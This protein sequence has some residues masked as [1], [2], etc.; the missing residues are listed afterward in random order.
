MNNRKGKHCF[1]C[2]KKNTDTDTSKAGYQ[3]RRYSVKIYQKI[4]NFILN[5][6]LLALYNNTFLI[7]TTQVMEQS[8]YN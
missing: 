1:T 4:W 5:L 3:H 6:R 2:E 7:Q 8:K